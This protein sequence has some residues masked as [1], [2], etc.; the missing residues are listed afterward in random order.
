MHE[1]LIA[2]RRAQIL[3]AAVNV[4]AE[5]G[6]QRA[7]IKDVAR[8]AGVADGTI[9]NY[10]ENKT[11]L[12]MGILDRL[13]D[14]QNRQQDFDQSL[15]TDLR[16]FTRQYLRQRFEVFSPE[17]MPLMQTLLAELLV[18]AELRERYWTQVIA[19]TFDV[20][21]PYVERWRERDNLTPSDMTLALHSMAALVIGLIMMRLM[22]D[23]TIIEHWEKLPNFLSE[24]VLFGVLGEDR[25]DARNDPE[26]NTNS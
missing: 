14:T 20:V 8:A 18:N 24:F 11:A 17:L 19:P 21:E 16:T 9:Y 13:N 7:T 15:A 5:K 3:V 23:S 22:G 4:F 10:F 12:L 25:H 26:G 1:Q 6:F 2:L